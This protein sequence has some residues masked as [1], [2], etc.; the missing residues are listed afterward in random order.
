M[1]SSYN[2]D[3]AVFL[4]GGIM[5]LASL[6]LSHFHSAYWLWF[7]AFIGLNMIQASFTGFCP[8]A[9]LFRKLGLPAGCAFFGK[10]HSSR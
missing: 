8:P 4:F 7:T 3:R 6:L 10:S 9:Y 5:I 1:K 2:I